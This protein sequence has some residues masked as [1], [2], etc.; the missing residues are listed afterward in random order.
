M[1][2]GVFE[3]VVIGE[4]AL[5]LVEEVVRVDSPLNEPRVEGILVVG[6][7]IW[8]SERSPAG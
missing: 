6:G 5:A 1:E 4:G 8:A 7:H 2:P 3:Q